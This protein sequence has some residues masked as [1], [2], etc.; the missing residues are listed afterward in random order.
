MGN[1]DVKLDAAP[2]P[3]GFTPVLARIE[4]SPDQ[5]ATTLEQKVMYRVVLEETSIPVQLVSLDGKDVGG[6]TPRQMFDETGRTTVDI[7]SNLWQGSGKP[8]WSLQPG[9]VMEWYVLFDKN[10]DGKADAYEHVSDSLKNPKDVTVHWRTEGQHVVFCYVA[11]ITQEIDLKQV[12]IAKLAETHLLF[13]Q[14]VGNWPS[15]QFRQFRDIKSKGATDPFAEYQS[16][17]KYLDVIRAAQQYRD[18]PEHKRAA[19]REQVDEYEDYLSALRRLMPEIVRTSILP[20]QKMLAFAKRHKLP[21]GELIMLT[22]GLGHVLPVA[23]YVSKDTSEHRPL[24]L[25]LFYR[26]ELRDKQDMLHVSLVDWTNPDDQRL[27]GR[28]D[29]SDPSPKVAVQAVL[30]QWR[31]DNQYYHP[32]NVKWEIPRIPTPPGVAR[33]KLNGPWSG[34]FDTRKNVWDKIKDF[35]DSAALWLAAAAA[36]LAFVVPIPGAQIA[37]PLMWEALFAGAAASV[38]SI[39]RRRDVGF[40]D[41]REDAR[42]L[43]GIAGPIFKVG[44]VAGTIA[45]R[46]GATLA[47]R[48]IGAKFTRYMAYGEWASDRLEVLLIADQFI[49]QFTELMNSSD[50][51]PKERID[52]LLDFLKVTAV[53]KGTS[54]VNVLGARRLVRANTRI[55]TNERIQTHL[56]SSMLTQLADPSATI[57]LDKLHKQRRTQAAS[58]EDK[59][60]KTTVQDEPRR[61]V[62]PGDG[63]GGKGG[64]GH[65]GRGGGGGG[66]RKPTFPADDP[67]WFEP[68]QISDK[69]IGMQTKKRKDYPRAYHFNAYINDEKFVTVNIETRI[70]DKHHPKL[71]TGGENFKRMFE[72]FEYH[73]H[74]I[75]GWE[76]IM[77][78]KNY[79]Q[80]AK[81]KAKN[82]E[83]SNADALLESVTGRHFW[84]PWAK[85][86]NLS[87]VVEEAKDLKGGIFSFRV[88]FE[89]SKK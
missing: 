32:G 34:Q 1:G 82:P 69:S 68:H 26:W 21:L 12:S 17:R 84:V 23:S 36:V 47:S 55:Q 27:S 10:G 5:H 7:T 8:L 30:N 31:D 65:S 28:Y 60:S 33:E 40:A 78:D 61:T 22:S 46:R 48:Q 86:K 74:E 43:L 67:E 70:D 2:T 16:L 56:E 24:R 19:Y 50:L 64:G 9:M 63:G 14:W 80:I 42:D 87:I 54:Y 44:K 58:T 76:G 73:G 89:R 62:N 81:V 85:S 3:V 45:W 53:S 75:K 35:L 52:K 6:K 20:D 29:A 77:V 37:A 13:R 57:D 41:W 25:C 11:G 51:D 59:R 15:M 4:A 88:R 66:R 83:M 39:A 71:G 18:A 49:E 72:H 79:E 38:I